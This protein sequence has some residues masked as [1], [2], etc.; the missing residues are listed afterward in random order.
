[1]NSRRPVLRLCLLLC[2]IAVVTLPA[3]AQILYNNGPINGNAD[4]WLISGDSSVSDTFT[5]STGPSTVTG[6]AFGAWLFPGDV[7]ENAEVSI[8]SS[9]FG[10]TT[11]FSQVVNFTQSGCS[12]NEIGFDVCTETSS[13]NGPNLSNG[14]YWV[15]LAGAF[16]NDADPVFWDQNSGVSCTSPG[17]PSE[18]SNN[19]V[20]TIPSESFSILGTSSSTS[21]VPEPGSLVLF[22]GG[23]LAIGGIL[24][25]KVL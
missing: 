18:A 7:L 24:R 11:Y 2:V 9:E 21:T 10:G 14:T 13:F 1:M 12:Q 16:V 8:T 17:C 20:G 15:N 5:I 6:M 23:V 19:E 3:A 25:R 4:A 22:A